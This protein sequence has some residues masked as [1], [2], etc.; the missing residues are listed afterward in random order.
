MAALFV[1]QFKSKSPISLSGST[2]IF[3]CNK[4][5]LLLSD[6]HHSAELPFGLTLSELM[7]KQIPQSF[8]SINFLIS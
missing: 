6:F 2:F 1:C 8:H 5:L 4:I 3:N 7:F